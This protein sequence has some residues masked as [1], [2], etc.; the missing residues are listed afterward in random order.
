M[1]ADFLGAALA[2]RNI[3]ERRRRGRARACLDCGR[4]LYFAGYSK[5]VEKRLP[6]FFIQSTACFLLFVGAAVGT[7]MHWANV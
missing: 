6:G 3:P 7:F 4:A 2:L 5:A 1:D